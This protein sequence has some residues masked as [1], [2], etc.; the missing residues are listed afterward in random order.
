METGHDVYF[1]IPPHIEFRGVIYQ[2]YHCLNKEDL[3]KHH[4]RAA[5]QMS[6][7]M[8]DKVTLYIDNTMEYSED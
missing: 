7:L 3:D 4:Q 5:Q 8:T 1:E 6:D 2:S